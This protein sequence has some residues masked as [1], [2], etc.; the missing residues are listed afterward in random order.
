MRG[1]RTHNK[2]NPTCGKGKGRGGRK[3]FIDDIVSKAESSQRLSSWRP[4]P[5]RSP[6]SNYEIEEVVSP[7]NVEKLAT[8]VEEPTGN[9]E[10]TVEIIE[11]P[12]ETLKN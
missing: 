7:E 12:F 3:N 5:Q 9:I 11:E 4:K 6:Q 8:S 1:C 10:E 2:T